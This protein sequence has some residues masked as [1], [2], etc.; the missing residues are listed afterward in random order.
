MTV[1]VLLDDFRAAVASAGVPAA[2]AGLQRALAAAALTED[3]WLQLGEGL[4]RSGV[5]GLAAAIAERGLDQHVRA[6]TLRVLFGNALRLVGERAAAE[7]ELRAVLAAEPGHSQAAVSLAHLL[8]ELGR[9]QAAGEAILLRWGAAAPPHADALATIGFLRECGLTQRAFEIAG[10][11]L[12]AHPGDAALHAQMG[13]LA[14]ELGRFEQARAHLRA[15]LDADPAQP[16]LWVRLAAAHRFRSRDET[17]VTRIAALAQRRGTGDLGGIAAH[18]ALGKIETDLGDIAAAVRALR[19]G[20]AAM[21]ARLRWSR[22][23]WQAFVERQC[24]LP[25]PQQ[26]LAAAPQRGFTPVLIVGLPRSGTTLAA[27]LLA[28]HRAVRG[29]GELNWLASLATHVESAGRDAAAVVRASSLYAAQLRGDDTP[30]RCYIDK[31]PL[32]FRH[33]GHAAALLPGLRVIHC[34]RDLHD[35][36]LSLWQQMF[37]HEDNA[38]AYDFA[39]IAAYA[40]GYRRLMQHWQRVLDVPRFELDYETLVTDTEATL[41]RLHAF[42]G[43]EPGLAEDVAPRPIRTASVWQARQ[44]I[45]ADSVGRWRAWAPHLPEL[46][47]AFAPP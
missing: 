38:Y 8:R 34:R 20:N 30:A 5:P 46:E 15:S 9:H 37:A 1:A 45:H 12:K 41:L 4:L 17:D 6:H 36:A 21:H 2:Y 39:D 19:A 43:L 7:R 31:N 27:T 13:E 14:L 28:R 10:S 33:L 42:L 11:A 26:P 16:G 24:Q 18:F 35:T 23:G 44:K 32:N 40:A 29:R 3:D 25:P 47:A 22:A